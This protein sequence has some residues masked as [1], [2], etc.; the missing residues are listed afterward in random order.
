LASAWP[1]S[2]T[3]SPLTGNLS[4]AND[5]AG[6]NHKLSACVT[7]ESRSKPLDLPCAD[8]RQGRLRQPRTIRSPD[9]G[10]GIG[11]PED[12]RPSMG[13]PNPSSGRGLGGRREPRASTSLVM[14]HRSAGASVSTEPAVLPVPPASV[15][16]IPGRLGPPA[17]GRP[18]VSLSP[19]QAARPPPHTFALVLAAAARPHRLRGQTDLGL[20][21][22]TAWVYASCC[23]SLP[24]R[25][26]Q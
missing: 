8:H 16:E 24:S 5:P 3:A 4:C 25:R 10:C 6:L 17:A 9:A 18:G 7:A 20:G 15:D 14:R 2:L 23:R 19:H 11:H 22:G 12:V 13:L 26:N 21:E 1:R